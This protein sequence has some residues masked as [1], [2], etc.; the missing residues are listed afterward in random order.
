MS[1]VLE[2]YENLPQK[3]KEVLKEI[4]ERQYQRGMESFFL[5]YQIR[6]A[7]LRRDFTKRQMNILLFICYYSFDYGK[8]WALI[9][10]IR[11]FENAGII[12][13]KVRYELSKL[14][15]MNVIEWNQEENLFRIKEPSVWKDV[16]FNSGFSHDRSKEIRVLNAIH[17]GIIVE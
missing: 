13:N 12:A 2:G 8:E 6:T 17:A 10:K 14:E 9:P 5:E 3:Q 7:M 11:D 1:W 16:P 15:E 4:H